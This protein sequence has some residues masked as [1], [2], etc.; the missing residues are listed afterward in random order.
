MFRKTKKH[1][2]NR[3][4]TSVILS[5]PLAAASSSASTPRTSMTRTSTV[6]ISSAPPISLL[7][8]YQLTTDFPIPSCGINIQA[9]LIKIESVNLFTVLIV[10]GGVPV[11]IRMRM[12]YIHPLEEGTA[13]GQREAYIRVY[14]YVDSILSMFELITINLVSIDPETGIY[15]GTIVIRDGVTLNYSLV[16]MGYAKNVID[17]HTSLWTKNDY[18]SIIADV[19][20]VEPVL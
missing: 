12:K 13:P 10:C 14:D 2:S 7:L 9:R 6:P 8:S 11:S 16:S 20:M 4:S 1:S 18:K 19:F 3:D 5:T 15:E 17:G